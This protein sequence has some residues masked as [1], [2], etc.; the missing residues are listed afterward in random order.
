MSFPS[1]K[2][3]YEQRN[4]CGTNNYA[5]TWGCDPTH[6]HTYAYKTTGDHGFTDGKVERKFYLLDSDGYRLGPKF[7]GTS[8]Y[9][10]ALKA[11]TKG[12][13]NILIHDVEN[14]VVRAYD[15]GIEPIKNPTPYNLKYGQTMRPF[16]RS[17]GYAYV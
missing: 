7:T 12:Y 15:G 11:A 17:I 4:Y 14:N 2:N 3:S 13:K 9:G 10:A 1:R 16:V 6:P 8:P 5:W